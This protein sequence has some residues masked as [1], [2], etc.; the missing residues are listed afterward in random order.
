MYFSIEC[1]FRNAT[2][3]VARTLLSYEHSPISIGLYANGRDQA[4]RQCGRGWLDGGWDTVILAAY[5][6]KN[7]Q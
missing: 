7:C 5:S 2:I 3:V 6:Q 1:D 4:C